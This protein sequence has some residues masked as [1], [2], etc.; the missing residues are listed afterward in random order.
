M[1]TY[2]ENSKVTRVAGQRKIVN[3]GAPVLMTEAIESLLNKKS[4]G[5]KTMSLKEDNFER[6]VI[7]GDVVLCE[8]VV[9]LV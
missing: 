6:L 8:D 5:I 9:G 7:D 3:S 4:V 1:L 2:L